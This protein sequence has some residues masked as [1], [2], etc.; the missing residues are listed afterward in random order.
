MLYTRREMVGTEWSHG[1]KRKG[2][3]KEIGIRATRVDG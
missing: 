2:D 3:Q 1:M